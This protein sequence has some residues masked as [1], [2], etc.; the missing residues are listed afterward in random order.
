MSWNIFKKERIDLKKAVE[1]ALRLYKR[2][3]AKQLTRSKLR[4]IHTNEVFMF[5]GTNKKSRDMITNYFDVSDNAPDAIKKAAI[6]WE[7]KIK[8]IFKEAVA[9]G[10]IYGDGYAEKVFSGDVPKA[11]K[12]PRG[13]FEDLVMIDSETIVDIDDK[14]GNLIQRGREK[15]RWGIGLF[16]KKQIHPDRVLRFTPYKLGDQIFGISVYEVAYNLLNSKMKADKA[17]GNYVDDY[18]HGFKVLNIEGAGQKDIDDGYNQMMKLKGF[19]VGSERH[20]LSGIQMSTFNPDAFNQFFY[21]G[22]AAALDMPP[23]VLLGEIRRETAPTVDRMEY[24]DGVKADQEIYLTPLVKELFKDIT[25]I[26]GSEY[27]IIWR[28]LYSDEIAEATIMRHKA[29]AA[30]M[31][32]VAVGEKPV[33]TVDEAREIMGLP[34][35]KNLPRG[36]KK[37][38]ESFMEKMIEA[39]YR[40]EKDIDMM[41]SEPI[42]ESDKTAIDIIKEWQ[43]ERKMAKEMGYGN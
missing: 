9:S 24:Y 35:G 43:K 33:L 27:Q 28:P 32:F 22:I 8:A 15:R 17:Y 31:L 42:N 19:F 4:Q 29:S 5:K 6:E 2:L 23:K 41:N 3:T 11:D 12:A 30:R 20:K 18:G 16:A 38:D 14:T 10:Y 36:D 26:S 39:S 13:K 21:L 40:I 1:K 34:K 7:D 25:G 37:K